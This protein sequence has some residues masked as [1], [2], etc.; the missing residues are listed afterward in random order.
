VG[1]LVVRGSNVMRGYWGLPDETA[2]GLRPGK[3]PGE[4]V[5]YTGD[6]FRSDEEGFL[7]FVGR[8][9]DMIKSRGER[10]SPKEIEQCL[11]IFP[12]VDDAAAF[13]IPDEILGQAIQAYIRLHDGQSL[14]EKDLLIHCKKNLEDFMIP[15]TVRFLDTFPKTSSG[16]I[17]KLTLK[18]QALK[19][20]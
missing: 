19:G 3:Y 5:L 14:S 8:K 20:H 7:Y 6:L 2:R 10:I 16:K 9:D 4:M 1:E 17:D 13:G 15:Q 11:C 18:E 12:G